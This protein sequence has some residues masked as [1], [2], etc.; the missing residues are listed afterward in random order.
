M[1]KKGVVDNVTNMIGPLIV[2]A[3]ALVVGLLVI[4]NAKTVIQDQGNDCVAMGATAIAYNETIGKCHSTGNT[5]NVSS[6]SYAINASQST[7]NAINDVPPWLPIVIITMVG[8]ILIGL[9]TA[10]R[11]R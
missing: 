1:N 9:V 11:R 7:Q 8:A 6:P 4:A 5:S 3:L 10:F 2:I